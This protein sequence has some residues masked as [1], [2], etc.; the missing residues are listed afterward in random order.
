MLTF[1]IGELLDN[2]IPI[3][4]KSVSEKLNIYSES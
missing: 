1:V 2:G 4:N 3:T